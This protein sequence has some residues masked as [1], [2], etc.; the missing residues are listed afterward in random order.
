MILVCRD[1]K[2]Q[3]NKTTTKYIHCQTLNS[4][5]GG[6]VNYY[7]QKNRGWEGF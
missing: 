6:G 4:Y 3:P 2:H 1:T 5:M 7:C